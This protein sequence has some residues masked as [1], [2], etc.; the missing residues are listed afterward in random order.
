MISGYFSA[1]FLKCSGVLLSLNHHLTWAREG[2]SLFKA[3]SFSISRLIINQSL[4][5]CVFLLWTRSLSPMT[6]ISIPP[7]ILTVF[8]LFQSSAKDPQPRSTERIS[9][10]FLSKGR[11]TAQHRKDIDS[12]PPDI[13]RVTSEMA[14][15]SL[16][17][18]FH[19]EF[20]EVNRF[21]L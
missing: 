17:K 10:S 14:R 2:L 7:P 11:T 9:I 21:R 8:L 6:S 19:S 18:I 15:V 12:Q 3:M 20:R 4:S 16:A 1:N 13:F 5:R